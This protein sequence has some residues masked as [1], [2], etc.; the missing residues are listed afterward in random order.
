MLS[1]MFFL[2]VGV[3]ACY[4]TCILFIGLRSYIDMRVYFIVTMFNESVVA[5]NHVKK[6]DMI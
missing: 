4:F 1:Y 6:I 2:C 3:L 5:L